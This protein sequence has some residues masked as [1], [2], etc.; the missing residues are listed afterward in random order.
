SS[1]PDSQLP[2]RTR[3]RL[4]PVPLSCAVLVQLVPGPSCAVFGWLLAQPLDQRLACREFCPAGPLGRLDLGNWSSMARDHKAAAF[5]HP[6]KEAG[7]VAV[8]FRGCNWFSAHGIPPGVVILPI[9]R[10]HWDAGIDQGAEEQVA[11][12]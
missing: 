8:G 4:C 1:S 10:F 12:D 11:A 3:A 6:F 5:P 9:F 2:R 7:E